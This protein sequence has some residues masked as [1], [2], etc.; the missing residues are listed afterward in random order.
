MAAS[1]AWPRSRTA[2]VAAWRADPDQSNATLPAHSMGVTA[3]LRDGTGFRRAP[4]LRAWNR[5]G[6][7]QSGNSCQNR[8]ESDGS[9]RS[10]VVSG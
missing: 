2:L 8:E 4:G 7:G 1:P 6:H 3:D 5:T 10:D 9:D